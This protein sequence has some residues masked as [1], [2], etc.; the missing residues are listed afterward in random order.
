MAPPPDHSGHTSHDALSAQTVHDLRAPLTVIKAQ[1]GMLERWVRRN[2]IA[3]GEAA[4]IRLSVID[5]MVARLVLELD[6]LREV[7][8]TSAGED[9]NGGTD[10]I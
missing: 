4:L 5:A 10:E 3:G 2:D 1:A 8:P 9:P 7:D 6:A